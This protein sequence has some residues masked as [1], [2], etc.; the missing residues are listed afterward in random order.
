LVPVR[1]VIVFFD[2]GLT[3]RLILPLSYLLFGF[4]KDRTVPC[5]VICISLVEHAIHMSILKSTPALALVSIASSRV[6]VL[7]YRIECLAPIF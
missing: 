1:C 2:G 7:S 3:Q 5:L 4:Q 6:V